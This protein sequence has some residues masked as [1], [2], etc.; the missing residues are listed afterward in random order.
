MFFPFNGN[1]LF[2]KVKNNVNTEYL[3]GLISFNKLQ[4]VGQVGPM[5]GPGRISAQLTWLD[6]ISIYNC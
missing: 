1:K 3:K 5:G 4:H 6:K 2:Y